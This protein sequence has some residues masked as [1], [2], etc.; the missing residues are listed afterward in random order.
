MRTICLHVGGRPREQDRVRQAAEVRKG[1]A[2]VGHQLH[3]VGEHGLRSDRAPELFDDSLIHAPQTL[4]KTRCQLP[5]CNSQ[6]PGISELD[7]GSWDLD[8]LDVVETCSRAPSNAVAL[9]RPTCEYDWTTEPTVSR[10]TSRTSASRSS[11]RCPD[12]RSR[13]RGQRCCSAIRSPLETGAARDAGT[14]RAESGD[15]GLRRHARTAAESKCCRRSSTRCRMSAP[16]TSPSSSPPEP[17][18]AIPPEELERMLGREILSRYKVINHDSRDASS[19]GARRHDLH[20]RTRS[21]LNRQWLERGRPHH[22]RLSS[23]RTSSP[24]S[25]ADRRWSRPGWPGSRR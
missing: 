15:L 8:R 3:R 25:A 24:A 5:N 10:S 4:L 2:L 6:R 21:Y 20:G 9:R 14:G 16:R 13:T 22:D 19:L 11:S 1:V 23:S 12:R 17:T 18:A 7:L